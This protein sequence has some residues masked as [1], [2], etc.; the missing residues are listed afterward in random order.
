MKLTARERS[1][2]TQDV[3]VNASQVW[4]A[5]RCWRVAWRAHGLPACVSRCII[6][7]IIVLLL[8]RI[9]DVSAPNYDMHPFRRARHESRA[10]ARRG[11]PESYKSW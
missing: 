9:N 8:A 1:N 2:G 6:L 3:I 4:V 5:R 7:Y 10:G 11:T